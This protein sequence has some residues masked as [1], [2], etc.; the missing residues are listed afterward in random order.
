M[1]QFGT[2]T[3][4]LH[5]GLAAAS[6]VQAALFSKAGITAGSDTLHGPTG[7]GT[8]MVGQD[9]EEL[10]EGM[11]GKIEHGQT[12]TF[13][14]NDIGLP[15]HIEEY[16]LKVKRF[17]NC[18]SIHRALDGLLE[19]REKHGFTAS[20]VQKILVRA[21]AAHLRNLMYE[22]PKNS[23]EAKFSLEYSLAAG[24]LKGSVGLE[25]YE[26]DNIS[27]PEIT[28]LLPLI[29]KEYVEKLE[30]DF[31]TQVHVTLDSGE[32]VSTEVAMPVGST[33]LPLSDQ[34]LW[35]KFDACVQSYMNEKNKND[36]KTRLNNLIKEPNISLMMSSMAK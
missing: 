7:M 4:P 15:L 36:I 23:M 30:T 9:V 17:P 5:A 29:H 20:N 32:T 21:P 16:G 6:A 35:D 13:A 18:G 26:E 10:R 31:Y 24:L 2:M 19:L 11:K 34:Q 25:E 1:S 33:A 8:L 3:K 14:A 22:R 12:V 27:N 28:E